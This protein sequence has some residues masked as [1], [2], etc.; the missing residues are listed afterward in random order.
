MF[1]RA[2]KQTIEKHY[3][4]LNLDAKAV[5]AT[6]FFISFVILIYTRLFI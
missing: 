2:A 6:A 1:R 3:P 5:G 4:Q